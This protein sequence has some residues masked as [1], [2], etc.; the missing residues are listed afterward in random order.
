MDGHHI[1]FGSFDYVALGAVATPGIEALRRRMA[2]EL[3]AGSFIAVDGHIEGV[4]LFADRLRLET[5][6]TLRALRRAGVERMVMLTG[7]QR[8]AAEVIGRAAGVDEVRAGLTPLQKVESVAQGRRQGHTAMVGDGINDAPA[9]AAADVGIALAAG[10]GT[11]S[12]EAAS[13]VLLVDRLDRIPET[14]LIARRSRRIAVQSVTVGMGLSLLAML[15]AALGMLPP[16]AGALVQ[17]GIDVLVILNALRALRG[18]RRIAAAALDSEQVERLRQ[19][20]AALAPLLTRVHRLA[21]RLAGLPAA[22]AGQELRELVSDLEQRLLPHEREDEDA[23][24]PRLA[25]KLAGE[26]PL[27]ALSHTHREIFR[28]GHLLGRMSADLS[29]PPDA[30]ALAEIQRRLLQLDIVL[31][32]H[33]ADEDELY[34]NLD[35]R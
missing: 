10:G 5:P 26:D 30:E 20:H 16:L 1:V 8:E 34:H 11:A 21:E 27:A 4:A 9:L 19:E 25:D 14:L 7:D 33:F 35:S 6:Y 32:L 13:V 28:L 22:Q 17:E 23:L 29:D 3:A 18:G 2:Y 24:F 31:S 12:S 15:F